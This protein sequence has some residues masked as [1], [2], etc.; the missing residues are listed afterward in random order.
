MGGADGRADFGDGRGVAAAETSSRSSVGRTPDV[1]VTS[2]P[3]TTSAA[4]TA[5][6]PATV[7]VRRRLA[8]ARRRI[9]G[10]GQR[11]AATISPRG[12]SCW[13][14]E[15]VGTPRW[16]ANCAVAVCSSRAASSAVNPTSRAMSAID[17]DVSWISRSALRWMTGSFA[18]AS[19]VAL[20][21][22]SRPLSRMSSRAVW[23]RWACAHA[24]GRTQLSGSSR[25][26]ILRQWCQATT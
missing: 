13:R 2:D 18:S 11:S 1:S 9:G 15:V 16:T 10:R 6:V 26:E 14:T 21:S 25:R 8:P 24:C 7:W 17:S 4:A 22:G 5:T 3:V 23:R 12:T 20:T 19:S